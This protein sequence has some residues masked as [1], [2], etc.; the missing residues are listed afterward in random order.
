VLDASIRLNVTTF[1]YEHHL[2]LSLA[3]DLMREIKAER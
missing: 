3:E 2:A 1:D